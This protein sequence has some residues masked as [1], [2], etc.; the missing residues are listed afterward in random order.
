M[1]LIDNNIKMKLNELIIIILIIIAI[2]I[3]GAVEY[4]TAQ[5]EC[6]ALQNYKCNI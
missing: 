2:Y 6:E 1:H 4:N 3:L 5:I